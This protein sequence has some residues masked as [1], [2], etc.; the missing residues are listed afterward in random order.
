[1]KRSAA[2]II[3]EY[4]PFS[5]VDHVH[6]LTHDGRD[7]WFAAGDKLV[8]L[9]PASGKTGR[10]IDVPA[11]AGTAF[12]G[13]HLF[14]IAE[15]RIQKIDPTTGHVL[16]TI[17]APGTSNSGLAWAEGTLWVGQHRDRK[18]HQID[19]ETGAI[20]R[21][22]QSNR[23][24]TGVTW[25]D[26]E[27]WHGTWEGEESDLRQIDAQTGEVLQKIEMPTGIRVS[28]LESDGGDRFFCGGGPSGTIRAVR[29]PRRGAPQQS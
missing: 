20:L 16:G 2:E 3:R 27:L 1:M 25:I 4:G 26:G 29:R 19:P 6:G 24:V 28:G 9:D 8:A 23:F 7:V 17:P 11:H 18:I 14:Q 10:A 22:I 12:D 21:T 5:G 15:G 13:R